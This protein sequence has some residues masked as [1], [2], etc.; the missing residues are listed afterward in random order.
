MRLQRA[1]GFLALFALVVA[2]C[3][4]QT[5]VVPNGLVVYLIAKQ[6]ATGFPELGNLKAEAMVE[7]NQ[8]CQSRG[9]EHRMLLDAKN[10]L[11]Q[12]G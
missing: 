3:A 1:G 9:R 2:G 5:G 11:C 10:H 8:Y 12:G 6:A 7:A 4:S